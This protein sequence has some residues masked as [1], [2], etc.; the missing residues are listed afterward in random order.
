[1]A[2]G[3]SGDTTPVP[4]PFH[5]ERHREPRPVSAGSVGV[6]GRLEAKRAG[7]STARFR[8]RSGRSHG[9]ESKSESVTPDFRRELPVRSVDDRP[10]GVEDDLWSRAVALGVTAWRWT[11]KYGYVSAVVDSKGGG[12]GLETDRGRV[13]DTFP[14]TT[15]RVLDDAQFGW[16]RT[17]R[18]LHRFVR[19]RCFGSNDGQCRRKRSR[20][21][22]RLLRAATGGPVPDQGWQ[23]GSTGTSGV[24]SFR[25][26]VRAEAAAP[27]VSSRI[28]QLGGQR[29]PKRPPDGDGERSWMVDPVEVALEG[30]V[31]A[32]TG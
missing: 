14:S 17:R 10:F 28:D 2:T 32:V 19:R 8:A 31:G 4:R 1:M 6:A 22:L 26:V 5:F 29:T 13:P 11:R 16:S 3:V 15:R 21:T 20:G 25:C 12:R 7:V 23:G 18:E 30:R 27:D 9:L 24:G